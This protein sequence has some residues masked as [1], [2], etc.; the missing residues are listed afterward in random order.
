M[1]GK[2]KKIEEFKEFVKTKPSLISYVKNNNMTWQQFYDIWDLYGPNHEEWNKYNENK[3][4]KKSNNSFNL[5]EFMSMFKKIDMDTI[6]KGVNGLQKVVGL[7]QDIVNKDDSQETTENNEPY[8]P[9]P[10]F[11]RF[12]D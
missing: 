12:E 8:K 7:L 11:K 6:N 3:E 2:M 1:G 9:R 5:S 4:Q 10:M